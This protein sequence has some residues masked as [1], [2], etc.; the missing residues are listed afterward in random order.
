[1][2]IGFAD[3][4][5]DSQAVFRA[6]LDA[7]SR[8]GTVHAVQALAEPPAPLHRATAAVLLTLADADTPVWLD[9]AAAAA[10]A[11]V[12]FHCGAPASGLADAAFAI[13]LQPVDMAGLHAGTDE[14][15]ERGATLVLQ[16]AALG[17]GQ[18]W[19]LSGPGVQHEAALRV[20]G[21]PDGFADAW[22]R[23]A[24]LFPRGVDVVLC[25]GDRLAALPRTVALRRG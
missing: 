4:V 24:A 7:M 2:N 13:A 22:A 11:W 19:L 25:A 5:A 9:S 18:A 14:A 16:V 20:D 17:E 21:L 1:M 3:S 6:V 10:R 8:P 23:N 15:P 12:A